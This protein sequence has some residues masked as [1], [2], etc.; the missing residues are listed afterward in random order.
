[1]C[2]VC[3]CGVC[4]CVCV[5]WWYIPSKE[6]V[7]EVV[8]WLS[9][10]LSGWV[11]L[12]LVLQVVVLQTGREGGR[13]G[14]RGREG[15]RERERERG[16]EGGGR[17]WEGGGWK[18]EGGGWKWKGGRGEGGREGE[19]EREREGRGREEVGK[20]KGGREVGGRE[21]GREGGMEE[22]DGEWYRRRRKNTEGTS[23]KSTETQTTNDQLMTY[24]PTACALKFSPPSPLPGSQILSSLPSSRL[25][26]SLLPPLFQAV[27]MASS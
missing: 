15:E 12:R 17:K 23:S 21:E 11:W 3:V 2:V 13:E 14:G 1:M 20:W 16:R 10:C 6:G 8:D 26:N 24:L 22:G 18:W 4:V 9:V 19:G 7:S 25:S 5:V 27:H